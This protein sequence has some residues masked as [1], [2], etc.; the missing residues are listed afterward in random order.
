M[1]GFDEGEG[2]LERLA[3]IQD[4]ERLTETLRDRPAGDLFRADLEEARAMAERDPR[5]ASLAA[6]LECETL[7]GRME[8][9]NRFFDE[10]PPVELAALML[11][12]NLSQL[13]AIY[14]SS[15]T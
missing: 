15:R 1:S 7:G 12:P 2:N 10:I 6:G 14:L 11:P 13:R 4:M 8:A 3:A 5:F 9:I